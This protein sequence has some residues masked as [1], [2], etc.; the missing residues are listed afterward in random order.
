M[1]LLSR[2]LMFQSHA[3]SIEAWNASRLDL[4]LVVFQSHAGSIEA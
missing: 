3:G 4:V 1:V 2:M